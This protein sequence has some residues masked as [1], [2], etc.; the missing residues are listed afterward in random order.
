MHDFENEELEEHKHPMY[1]KLS[2]TIFKNESKAT[3]KIANPRKRHLY[4]Q[5]NVVISGARKLLKCCEFFINI[6]VLIIISSAVH[7]KR[8]HHWKVIPLNC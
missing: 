6:I 1:S 8:I 4:R 2:D 3:R 5:H 7:Q